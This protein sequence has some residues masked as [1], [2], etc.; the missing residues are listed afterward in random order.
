MF[1]GS[2][3]NRSLS[4]FFHNLLKESYK[5][6]EDPRLSSPPTPVFP[7]LAHFSVAYLCDTDGIQHL[8]FK[9]SG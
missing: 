1:L 5:Q 2:M 4:L 7:S 3:V 6:H 8:H 9:T